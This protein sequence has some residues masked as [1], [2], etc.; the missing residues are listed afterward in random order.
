V[1]PTVV[2]ALAPSGALQ[3]ASAGGRTNEATEINGILDVM[4]PTERERVRTPCG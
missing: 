4:A 2:S 3:Q 1:E